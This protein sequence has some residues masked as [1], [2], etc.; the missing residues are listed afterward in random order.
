MFDGSGGDAAVAVPAGVVARH[1]W[2]S[3]LSPLDLAAWRHCLAEQSARCGWSRLLRA[4]LLG[5]LADRRPIPERQETA[6]S[7]AETSSPQFALRALPDAVMMPAIQQVTSSSGRWTP[8]TRQAAHWP[9][10]STSKSKRIHSLLFM[11]TTIRKTSAPNDR[12]LRLP[13]VTRQ[14]EGCPVEWGEVG[15]FL[16]LF[17]PLDAAQKFADFLWVFQQVQLSISECIES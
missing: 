8:L 17:R 3:R 4:A 14:R 11:G 7:P 13:P 16:R 5:C 12:E 2:L 15:K 6:E 1:R 9:L 10:R